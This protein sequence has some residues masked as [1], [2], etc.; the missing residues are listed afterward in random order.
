MITPNSELLT[1]NSSPLLPNAYS[2][3][4]Y[5]PTSST[6]SPVMPKASGSMGMN[7]PS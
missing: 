4:P 6:A 2:L 7:Q 3:I 5:L 1:P